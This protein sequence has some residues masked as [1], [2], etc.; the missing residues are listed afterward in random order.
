MEGG[1][2]FVG[3]ALSTE[4]KDTENKHLPVWKQ[5]VTDEEG[6]RRF[7]G[8]FTGGFSAGYYNTVG[9]KEGWTPSTYVSSRAKRGVI[10]Q[11]KEDFMDDED[12]MNAVTGGRA[13]TTRSEFELGEADSKRARRAASTAAW[14][15]SLG[16]TREGLIPG[17]LPNEL[18]TPAESPIGIKLLRLMGWREGQGIGPRR[19]VARPPASPPASAIPSSPLSVPP[20]RVYGLQVSLHD[21]RADQ[22][23]SQQE[24]DSDYL[25]TCP[26]QD[27][28]VLK[29]EVKSDLHGLGYDPYRHIGYA[30]QLQERRLGRTM[31]LASTSGS[32]SIA[33]ST[34]GYTSTSTAS[35]IPARKA[36]PI[37]SALMST[38]PA[39]EAFGLGAFEDADDIDVYTHDSREDYYTVLPDAEEGT[40]FPSPT[41]PAAGAL[42]T[43][44]DST[45][46]PLFV[47][48][49]SAS[50]PDKWFPP[51]DVP[52]DYEPFHHFDTSLYTD[53]TSGPASMNA[54]TRANILGER[55]LPSAA[56][57]S[58]GGPPTA[59]RGSVFDLISAKDK[60]RLLDHS[61]QLPSA[62]TST[63]TAGWSAGSVPTPDA[64]EGGSY[65]RFAG[66]PGKQMRF[67]NFLLE[68]S[69]QAGLP[70]PAHYLTLTPAQQAAE[71]LEFAEAALQ[72]KRIHPSMAHRFTPA[73][74]SHPTHDRPGEL[75]SGSGL[76][77]GSA[78]DEYQ[79]VAA[80]MK[81]FGKLTRKEE[82]WFPASLLCKRFNIKPPHPTRK[83]AQAHTAS[84]SGSGG[85]PVPP[86][87]S[88]TAE[89]VAMRSTI[90]PPGQP[91]SSTAHP[92]AANTDGS[93]GDELAPQSDRPPIDLFKAIFEADDEDDTATAG[94]AQEIASSQL[95]DERASGAGPA[96]VSRASIG[97]GGPP[98]APPSVEVDNLNHTQT[99]ATPQL[100]DGRGPASPPAQVRDTTTDSARPRPRSENPYLYFPPKREQR[101][102]LPLEASEPQAPGSAH[103]TKR[104]RDTDSPDIEDDQHSHK[105]R[106]KDKRNRKDKGQDKDRTKHR[107][108]ENRRDDKKRHHKQ[109]D[110]NRKRSSKDK[111]KRKDKSD[112]N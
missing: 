95:G 21:L 100:V 84:T 34:F 11:R 99:T 97:A 36:V 72:F 111:R 41:P 16:S 31:N 66:D 52:P 61:A 64:T 102:N 78:T 88:F 24:Q 101:G 14:N 93:D 9:S 42:P 30:A 13:L 32:A 59:H 70:I 25:Y 112:R 108:K 22:H 106:H 45:R 63:V 48:A 105:R 47:P 96:S 46:L 2:R 3:T 89:E 17:P 82:D 79:A 53:V 74:Q 90:P 110:K 23:Q 38:G 20:K 65:H 87:F 69:G 37:A 29:F 27:S 85:G 12:Y 75:P 50:L 92:P 104:D 107:D 8:A 15:E 28:Q 49:Q 103:H 58:G 44:N 10:Q 71:R 35:N 26:P 62:S 60:Q 55:P 80:S 19:A 67:R 6:R 7:H 5:E 43:S 56:V 98:S 54:Q 73:Q 94:A 83:S 86:V 91:A 81:M 68:Q 51:P 109:K 40:A 33:L 57:P 4:Q 1:W 77:S 39:G 18:I 76:A